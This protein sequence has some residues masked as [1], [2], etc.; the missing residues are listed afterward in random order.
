MN[1]LISGI[2]HGI[3]IE[4]I[5]QKYFGVT[6]DEF[7]DIASVYRYVF[8]GAGY[9]ANIPT[10]DKDISGWMIDENHWTIAHRAVIDMGF[11]LYHEGQTLE[12]MGMTEKVRILFYAG[13]GKECLERHGFPA[14]EIDYMYVPLTGM[15]RPEIMET[16]NTPEGN[17][18]YWFC[19]DMFGE[20]E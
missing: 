5:C 13:R 19:I 12:L 11:W 8:T 9:R 3:G 14:P 6:R 10:S 18:A 4:E 17:F 15:T 7:I 2:D 16:F 20:D 1:K